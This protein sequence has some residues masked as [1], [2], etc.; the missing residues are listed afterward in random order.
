MFIDLSNVY[1]ITEIPKSVECR[2]TI[3][4]LARHKTIII[5]RVPTHKP[6]FIFHLKH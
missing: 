1:F 5:I 3:L 2:I 4:P 6:I